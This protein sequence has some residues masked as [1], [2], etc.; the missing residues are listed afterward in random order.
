VPCCPRC[1]VNVFEDTAVTFKI[2]LS[3]MMLNGAAPNVVPLPT[4][5][6]V[7]E[8]LRLELSVVEA[9][10]LHVGEALKSYAAVFTL[11]ALKQMCELSQPLLGF[12]SQSY[13][14][15]LQLEI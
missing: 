13:Q 9:V 14:P 2:S 6:L 4:L 15:A 8:L 3:M 5:T 11:E 1:T 12:L 7:L 10:Q